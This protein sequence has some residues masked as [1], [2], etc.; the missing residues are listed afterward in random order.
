MGKKSKNLSKVKKK[1]TPAVADA[2]AAFAPQAP[3]PSLEK[4]KY[5]TPHLLVVVLAAT[6]APRDHAVEKCFHVIQKEEIPP[7]LFKYYIQREGYIASI[8]HEFLTNNIPVATET[9]Y[10]RMVLDIPR[11]ELQH[12]MMMVAI[13]CLITQFRNRKTVWDWKIL[14]LQLS[15]RAYAQIKALDGVN[16]DTSTEEYATMKK[17]FD[18]KK[19]FVRELRKHCH[20]NCK[21]LDPVLQQLKDEEVGHTCAQCEKDIPRGEHK[22]CPCHLVSYCSQK[23]RDDNWSIHKRLCKHHFQKSNNNDKKT[24]N[25]KGK[26]Q[27]SV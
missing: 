9:L 18:S 8:F 27:K 4:K 12:F 20:S 24:P 5:E 11:E 17:M 21:C 2:V 7:S 16:D 22:V 10:H 25:S 1:E 14:W 19:Y 15:V 6:A 13:D 23:C 26:E 3:A